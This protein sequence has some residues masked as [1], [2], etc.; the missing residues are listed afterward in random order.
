MVAIKDA[1]KNLGTYD[2]TGCELYTT[3][4]PC[5]MC[6]GAILW[7]KIEKVYYGC[8][9]NDTDKIGFRDEVFYKMLA[10]EESVQTECIERDACLELFTEY[11]EK[12]REIY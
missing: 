12:E 6:L 10:G 1:C 5:P 8:N 9:I 7:A 3:A 11:G 4:Q 2:L